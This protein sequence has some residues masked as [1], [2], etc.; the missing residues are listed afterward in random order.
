MRRFQKNEQ[1]EWV[2]PVVPKKNDAMRLCINMRVTNKAIKRI[3][4]PIPTAKGISIELKGATVS[5]KLDLN[6]AY[7]QLDLSLGSRHITT[8]NTQVGLY[9]YKW[10]NYG[11]NAAAEIFQNALTQVLQGLKGIQNIA[12]DI[13]VFGVTREEHDAT[14]PRSMFAKV[15]GE[16][17]NSKLSKVPIFEKNLEFFGLIYSKEG[18]QPDPKKI[19]AFVNVSVPKTVVKSDV[20]WE[21]QIIVLNSYQILHQ[22]QSPYVS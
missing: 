14:Y 10:I 6:K 5:T 17:T 12:D 21:W 13:I 9:R 4:H 15:R 3:R 20:C 7:Y 16:G 8:F 19:A 22:S 1:A 11:T 18:I 2:S